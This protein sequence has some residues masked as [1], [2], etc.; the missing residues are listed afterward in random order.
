VF[1][2]DAR[3]CVRTGFFQ[4][5]LL[6]V[7]GVATGLNPHRT[8]ADRRPYDGPVSACQEMRS[9]P[10]FGIPGAFGG[11]ALLMTQRGWAR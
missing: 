11:H 8:R 6:M 5:F 3:I 10:Q 7:G 9:D 4:S 1:E 2:P